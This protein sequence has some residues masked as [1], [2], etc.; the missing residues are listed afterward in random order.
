ME[1]HPDRQYADAVVELPVRFRAKEVG[2]RVRDPDGRPPPR[3]EVMVEPGV[4][5][6]DPDLR[7]ASARSAFIFEL[8][9]SDYEDHRYRSN[10]PTV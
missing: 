3:V 6:M 9:D 10:S 1:P 7:V 4:V 5:S 8:W 2:L